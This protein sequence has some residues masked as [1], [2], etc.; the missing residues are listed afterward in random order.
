[1]LED[2]IREI[3]SLGVIEQGKGSK[4]DTQRSLHSGAAVGLR[5]VRIQWVFGNLS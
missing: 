2:I 3:R 4:G 1:M 5:L